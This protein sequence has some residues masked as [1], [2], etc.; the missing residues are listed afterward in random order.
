MGLVFQAMA[1]DS[2]I[3][4]MD[5]AMETHSGLP[6]QKFLRRVRTLS[7]TLVERSPWQLITP[8]IKNKLF[9]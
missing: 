8:S 1:M 5:M 4:V 3:Q 2:G 9:I 7:R 6:D